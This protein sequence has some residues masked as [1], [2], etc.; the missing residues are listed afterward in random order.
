[1]EIKITNLQMAELKDTPK[2]KVEEHEAS[3]FC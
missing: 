3:P 2:I 1:M